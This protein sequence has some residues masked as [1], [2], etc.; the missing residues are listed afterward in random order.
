MKTY[1]KKSIFLCLLT[2]VFIGFS[3]K[4]QAFNPFEDIRDEIN[5]SRAKSFR[6]ISDAVNLGNV[7]DAKE[8]PVVSKAVVEEVEIVVALPAFAKLSDFINVVATNFFGSL[9]DN[10]PKI[11]NSK[12]GEGVTNFLIGA[13]NSDNIQVQ[14][15]ATSVL[16]DVLSDPENGL[17]LE[18]KE[19]IAF[20]MVNLAR[21]DGSV[22]EVIG[23]NLSGAQASIWND[24]TI[25]TVN[26][27][28]SFDQD[29]LSL[30]YTAI[31]S[32]PQEHT[33]DI[34]AFYAN[35]SGSW[36]PSVYWS[37]SS[38]PST[39]RI[40][41]GERN[42]T[43]ENII[44][45]IYHEISHS[46]AWNEYSY[47]GS[48]YN[49]E[50]NQWNN[51][52]DPFTELFDVSG[53][54]SLNFALDHGNKNALEDFAT[55]YSEYVFDSKALIGRAAT[56]ALEGNDILLQKLEVMAGI[57]AHE[58]EDGEM[59]TY[60]F[61]VNNAGEVVR[62]EIALEEISIN[63]KDYLLPEGMGINEMHF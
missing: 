63:G 34:T 36:D 30:I 51:E 19:N 48:D 27:D 56:Q 14:S 47:D 61:N 59:M 37:G 43:P 2:I 41:I 53:E 8:E 40:I 4:A 32:L 12:F 35:I 16:L 23:E 5:G 45:T 9:I 50:T 42:Q 17:D 38:E 22:K 1:W 15:A 6:R 20:T 25:L 31:S 24:F 54:D 52:N 49:A 62:Y 46:F 60:I 58:G 39:G 55:M 21:E 11:L 26:V 57:F 13:L 3:F 44:H 29:Q 18:T 7:G 28:R 10:N 33:E